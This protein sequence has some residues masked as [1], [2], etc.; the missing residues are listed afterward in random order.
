MALRYC[1]MAVTVEG[2]RILIAQQAQRAHQVGKSRPSTMMPK[3]KK[4][5]MTSEETIL[6]QKRAGAGGR[7]AQRAGGAGLQGAMRSEKYARHRPEA[8]RHK[9]RQMGTRCNPCCA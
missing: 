6:R 9:A 5:R 4:P 7:V 3:K 2:L 8:S 1:A